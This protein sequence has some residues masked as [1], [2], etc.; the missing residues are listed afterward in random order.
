MSEFNEKNQEERI[1]SIKKKEAEDLAQILSQKYKLPYLDL[2]RINIELDALKILPEKEAREGEIAIFQKV[3]KKISVAVRNPELPQTLQITTRLKDEAYEL[4][5]FMVS[6]TSLQRAWS[7][8]SEV[9]EFEEVAAGL[10]SISKEH[11][12]GYIAKITNINNFKEL[13]APIISARQLRTASSMVEA[14]LAG[15]YALEASDIHIEPQ[16]NEAKLRFRLDGVLNDII[17]FPDSVYKLLLSRIKL[18]GE[19][20]LNVADRPQD[21]RFT[22]RINDTDV[23]VRASSLPGAYGESIVLRVL[24][25]KAIDVSFE[26]LGMHESLRKI[27]EKAINKP[28]GMILTTGPTGSGKTTTLYAFIKKILSPEIKIITIENPVEYHIAGIN[29]S[30]IDL[31]K[32]YDFADALRAVLR[33][34]PDVI[35]VGEIRDLATAKTALNAALTGHLVFSTLHTNNAFGTVPRLIDLGATPNTIG[36][37]V[38]VSMAQR[39]LRVLCEKC[40]K[41]EKATAEEIEFLKKKL[42]ELPETIKKPPLDKLELWKAKGCDACNNMGYKGRIG[43]YE[44]FSIDDEAQRLILENPPESEYKKLAKHQNM[45]TME[46][47]AALKILDGK[48]SV[49][50]MRRVLGE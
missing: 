39:L 8:Y 21:G 46:Q 4:T 32:N 24:H 45:L 14:I 26:N 25:P 29:Q 11:L 13:L 27:I 40:K 33:Q 16:E 49:E 43:V 36:P 35:L 44:A 1:E 38:S 3:G 34:D 6:E 20:K 42:A 23:E 19:M 7:R 15:A 17:N 9:P 50:E 18:I 48:T 28:N 37:A 47:D 12:A 5:I 2:S 30:Q 22:I 31:S 41:K 10:I